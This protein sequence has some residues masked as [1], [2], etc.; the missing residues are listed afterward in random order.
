MSRHACIQRQERQVATTNKSKCND[1]K[2]HVQ[3]KRGP[4]PTTGTIRHAPIV[5]CHKQKLMHQG[6]QLLID[7]NVGL[8]KWRCNFWW[9]LVDPKKLWCFVEC[10]A[11]FLKTFVLVFF[12]FTCVC[13]FGWS[14][15]YFG[16]LG[17]VVRVGRAKW[18]WPNTFLGML[19]ICIRKR[20]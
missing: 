18:S 19:G 4:C 2:G 9:M 16:W 8:R 5:T 6:H 13:N 12:V 14:C 20:R 11:F 10:L 17:I 15:T 1:S 3:W 7:Y